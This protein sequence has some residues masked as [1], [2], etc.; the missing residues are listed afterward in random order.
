MTVTG[1]SPLIYSAPLLGGAIYPRQSRSAGF[2]E[3]G[4]RLTKPES[5]GPVVTVS[6]VGVS[7]ESN[8]LST[9]IQ[10]HTEAGQLGTVPPGPFATVDLGGA[11]VQLDSRARSLTVGARVVLGSG[12]A[13]L[14]N[15]E[16]AAP[17]GKAPLV[18]AGDFL[19]LVSATLQ[20]R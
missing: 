1:S 18:A 7:F 20:G 15:R 14:I 2:V 16:F 4:F 12:G 8:S 11:T 19:G 9:A 6:N 10:L 3:G 13:E 5:P 17:K